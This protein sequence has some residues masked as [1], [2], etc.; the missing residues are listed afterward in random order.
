MQ[1]M[2]ISLSLS[3]WMAIVTLI[4][5]DIWPQVILDVGNNPDYN[6]APL[7]ADLD[8]GLSPDTL[9]PNGWTAL[10]IAA[11]LNKPEMVKILKDKGA[12][13]DIQDV[14]KYTPL[15]HAAGLDHANVIN[16]LLPGANTEIKGPN[17]WTPLHV[18]A[19]NGNAYSIYTMSYLGAD[20]NAV[21]SNGGTPLHVAVGNNHLYAATALLDIPGT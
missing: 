4:H 15:H 11:G 19:G 17:Q 10:H 5:G 8:S 3:L 14:N 13:L 7:S 9:G 12:K 18:A 6:T 2:V 20:T 1:V 16:K 21:D